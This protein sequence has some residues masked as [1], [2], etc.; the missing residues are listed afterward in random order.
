MMSYG[1]FIHFIFIITLSGVWC[2]RAEEKIVEIGQSFSFDCKSDDSV[3]FGRRIGS[4]SP[5]QGTD[6]RYSYLQLNFDSLVRENILR[7]STDSAQSEHGG[8]Y[9]CGQSKTMNR[10]YHLVVAG[11]TKNLLILF[12]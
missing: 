11:K 4:W 6:N 3:Y 8:Y 2:Q 12:Y 9:A 5:V 10:V 7:V 1:P